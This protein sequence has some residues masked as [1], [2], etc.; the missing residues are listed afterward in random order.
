MK[1][2]KFADIDVDNIQVAISNRLDYLL[3]EYVEQEDPSLVGL[4]RDIYSS[5]SVLAIMGYDQKAQ[6]YMA[7]VEAIKGE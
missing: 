6:F 2:Y 7:R 5:I 4:W 1:S 3:F